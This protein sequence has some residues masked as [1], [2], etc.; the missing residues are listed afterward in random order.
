VPATDEKY[1]DPWKATRAVA[2]WSDLMLGETGGDIDA[3]VRAYHRVS[4]LA[5]L[6]KGNAYLANVIRK[7]RRFRRSED[8]TPAW[9]F[10]L[11]RPTRE[12]RARATS[13]AAVGVTVGARTGT[14]R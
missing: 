11:V 3:A 7:R 14:V 5:I 12:E 6:G 2:I 10:L 4:P 13:L 1:S 9:D 8:S